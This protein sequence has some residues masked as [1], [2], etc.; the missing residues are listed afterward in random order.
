MVEANLIKANID[1]IKSGMPDKKKN[2][3]HKK[4]KRKQ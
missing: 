1:Y 4:R 3:T 2:I